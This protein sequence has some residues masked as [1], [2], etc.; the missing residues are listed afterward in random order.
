MFDGTTGG[1]TISNSSI[2]YSTGVV[3]MDI[4]PTPSTVHIRYQQDSD[5][6]ITPGFNEICQLLEVDVDSISM[7]S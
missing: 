6:N 7:E 3:L 5:S 4:S 2:N 1:Y